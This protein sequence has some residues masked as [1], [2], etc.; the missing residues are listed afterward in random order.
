M[1]ILIVAR[2]YPTKKYPLNGIFEFDQAKALK[3]YGHKV[4]YL[5]VDLRSIRRIRRFGKF[6]TNINGIEIL[7]ISLP[8]GRVPK[9]LLY[10]IGKCALLFI[11]PKLI[12]KQGVPPDIIHAHFSGLGNI[13]AVLKKHLKRP[14]VITEH[15][16]DINNFNIKR[17]IKN[18]VKSAY[19][20]ADCLI[21]VSSALKNMIHYNFNI[22]SIV[23][24]NIVDVNSFNYIDQEKNSMFTFLSIGNLIQ[25]KAFNVLIKAFYEADFNSSIEL[26]I[27]GDG[28]ELNSLQNQINYLELN[29]QV[30]LLGFLNRN[31]ISKA[32]QDSDVF[33]L[34]SR[35]ETFGV[36]F[37]EAMAAGLPVIATKCGGP[38]D[39]IN[40]SNG[41][42]VPVDD[43]RSL[44]DALQEI[45]NSIDK[46]DRKSISN[47]CRLKF[48]PN[49][50]ASQ[51][52]KVYSDLLEDNK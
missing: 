29:N 10:F 20:N 11:Y 48:S 27:I 8:L 36:V 33:V 21:S 45:Y 12:R 9:S 24:P 41:L 15:G 32:M 22:N 39:F 23:I 43:V 4:V 7:N 3:N 25:L 13:A 17:S 52:T 37:I 5:S 30:K 49:N 14:L 1:Y 51:L 18:K 26:K 31:E 35:S 34:A 44:A 28:P 47:E 46:Y 40:K 2:G 50:I 38:E 6:W 16:S 42:L 19:K